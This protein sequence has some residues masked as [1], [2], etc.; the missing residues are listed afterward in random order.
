MRQKD[1]SLRARAGHGVANFA[2]FGAHRA[3]QSINPGAPGFNE[4]GLA[5]YFGA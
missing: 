2:V 3:S 1:V 5:L 4:C